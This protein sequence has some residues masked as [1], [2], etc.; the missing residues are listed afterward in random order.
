M[1]M[2]VPLQAFDVADAHPLRRARR[3]PSPLRS[4]AYAAMVTI[5]AH[6]VAITALVE[7]LHQANITRRPEIV[8]VHIDLQKK[9]PEDLPPPPAPV[10]VK[11]S[12][13]TAP[14]PLITIAPP[15][16]PVVVPSAAAPKPSVAGFASSPAL[17]NGLT[18]QGLLLAR[19]QQA[20]R[21]PLSAQARRQQGVVLLQFTMDRDGKVL[22]AGIEKSSGYDLLDQEALALIQRVQP[23][24]KPP[25]E[26]AGDPIALV[27]PIE[28]FIRK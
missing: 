22:T 24:P 27:V 11:P 18:W 9:E 10:L 26:V 6:I 1:N 21:Y 23:L 25:A 16:N 17:S 12:I 7:G 2:Q 5:A 14:V 15:P 8:T 13:I 4:R 20:K 28:F 19:L 3:S